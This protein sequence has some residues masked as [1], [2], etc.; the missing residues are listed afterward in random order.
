MFFG[1]LRAR[2]L[3]DVFRLGGK[4]DGERP[5]RERRDARKNVGVLYEFQRHAPGVF[6]ELLRRG[7]HRPVVGHGRHAD[8]NVRLVDMRV[9]GSVHFP[10]A[11]D[12][13]DLRAFGIGQGG[14]AGDQ[15]RFCAGFGGGLRDGITHATG[16][17]VGDAAHRVDGLPGWAGGDDDGEA[18]EFT[19]FEQ[20]R[21]ERGKFRRLEHAPGA[22]IATGL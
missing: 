10:R 13:N 2:I 3:L 1:K 15:N 22:D 5:W 6:L 17:F 19:G 4:P 8:K 20:L 14:R 7:L 21:S 9:D 16:A 12:A 18:V 11:G